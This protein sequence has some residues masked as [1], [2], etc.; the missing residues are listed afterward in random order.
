MSHSHAGEPYGGIPAAAPGGAAAL[1][2]PVTGDIERQDSYVRL[3]PLVK[4]LLAIPHYI[5]LGVLWIV[6][7]LA[8]I[9]SFFAVL[10]TGRYPR[11][12]FDYMV[13]VARWN[14]RVQA[15]VL[16][17]TD[18]YPPFTLK[19]V[20]DH[21]A[22]IEIEYPETVARW[23]PLVQWL[24]VLPY[25]IVSS[26]LARVVWILAFFAFFTI[27][28]TKRI[29]A[30]MFRMMVIPLRWEMRTNTYTWFMV[31]RYPPFAWA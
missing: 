4:W 15:Y 21:P 5:V 10:I 30:G 9:V 13:G 25:A 26:I 31:T 11:A 1:D 18:R 24:L 14:W 27:L 19:D 28:F 7:F 20:A 6:A 3:L 22:R 23:R 17:M 2:Y 16:L 12:I 8:L 29:P